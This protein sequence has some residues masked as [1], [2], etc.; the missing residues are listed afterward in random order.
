MLNNDDDDDEIDKSFDSLRHDANSNGIL[1]FELRDKQLGNPCF[2]KSSFPR[3]W[4][5]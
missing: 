2:C 4:C 1:V 5:V 3:F